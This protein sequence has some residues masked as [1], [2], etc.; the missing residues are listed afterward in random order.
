MPVNAYRFD[1]RWTIPGFSPQQVY[2]VLA[3]AKLLPEWWTGVYL[4]ATPEDAGAS[5]RVGARARVTARGFLPYRIRMTL[6]AT[7]LD[8][9][10]VV[11]VRTF[12]D[13]EGTWRA[14]LSADGAGGTYVNIIEEVVA[15]KPVIRLLS[16]FLKPLFAWN[17]YWTSP[18][19]QSGLRAYLAKQH[20]G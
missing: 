19:G 6:E 14:T 10:K 2:D 4:E 3:D 1:E 12:G 18:R 15:Q 16:P 7:V 11:G 5:P 9:A 8:P 17:H 20:G 13:L